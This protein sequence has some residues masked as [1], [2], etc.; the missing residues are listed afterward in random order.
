MSDKK[1]FLVLSMPM[2]GIRYNP[3]DVFNELGLRTFPSAEVVRL[4]DI[5]E[6]NFLAFQKY[7]IQYYG[8][9]Q[10]GT[11]RPM[12]L[13]VAG[14][15]MLSPLAAEIEEQTA[16]GFINMPCT[17]PA[18]FNGTWGIG[19]INGYGAGF[20]LSDMLTT[21]MQESLIYP[22][23]KWFINFPNAI[24]WAQSD[25]IRRF[26]SRFVGMSIAPRIP[27]LTQMLPGRMFIDNQYASNEENRVESEMLAQLLSNGLI[28]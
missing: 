27:N 22:T 10:D 16:T 11:A 18:D 28:C 25:Y 14:T 9:Q 23:A 17:Q 13:P 26:Y 20:G 4:N 5:A 21:L 6:A 8:Q 7:G 2:I 24:A 15:Y 19:A 12:S 3:Q 1:V